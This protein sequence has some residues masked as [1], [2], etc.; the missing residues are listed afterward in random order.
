MVSKLSTSPVDNFVRNHLRNGR[1]RLLRLAAVKIAHF[2]SKAV[3][4]M[5]STT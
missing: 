2:Q 5:K 4:S 1:K 3:K